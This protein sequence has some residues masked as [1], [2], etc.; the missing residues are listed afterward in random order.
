MFTTGYDASAIPAAYSD[1][2]R[3]EKPVDRGRLL[4]QVTSQ[5]TT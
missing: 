2:P 4:R 5:L 1:V 3:H